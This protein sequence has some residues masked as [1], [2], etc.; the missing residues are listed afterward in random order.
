MYK[1]SYLN[2]LQFLKDVEEVLDIY[3]NSN[4]FEFLTKYILHIANINFDFS[5]FE[6][7][8]SIVNYFRQ[9]KIFETP[10][11]TNIFYE[12]FLEFLQRSHHFLYVQRLISIYLWF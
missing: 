9:I 11:K 2:D 8:S 6:F 4:N 12:K 1:Y 10:Q 7:Y 5:I 3:Y